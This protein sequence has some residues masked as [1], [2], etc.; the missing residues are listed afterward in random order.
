MI[1]I[2]GALALTL[3]IFH[4]R[5]QDVDS[6]ISTIIPFIENSFSNALGHC[7]SQKKLKFN[8]LETID[9]HTDAVYEYS[10]FP[11]TFIHLRKELDLLSGIII[12]QNEWFNS[13]TSLLQKLKAHRRY[14]ER[15][16]IADDYW[17]FDLHEKNYLIDI[18]SDGSYVMLHILPAY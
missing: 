11:E 7:D 18:Y 15:G 8:G 16:D 3:F 2:A 9:E 4:A 5:A 17:Y 13:K 12:Y 10:D 1:K 6:V 14:D